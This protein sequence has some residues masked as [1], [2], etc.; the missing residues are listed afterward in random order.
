M[1][2]G[3]SFARAVVAVLVAAPTVAALAAC[4]T[5]APPIWPQLFVGLDGRAPGVVPGLVPVIVPDFARAATTIPTARQCAA[6]WNQH[7]PTTTKHW[8]ASRGAKSAAITAMTTG[9]GLIGTSKHYSFSQCAYGIR[10]G[11]TQLVAAVAPRSKSGAAWRGEL[12]RYRS[13]AALQRLARTFN[14][15]VASDGSLRL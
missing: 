9:A 13:S 2:W 14:A 11:Q 12:L 3:L 6:R 10:V 15:T 7:A 1:K 4:G 8:L 5:A